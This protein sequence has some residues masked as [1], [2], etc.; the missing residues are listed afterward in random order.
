MHN[1]VFFANAL[2]RTTVVCC[3]QQANMKLVKVPLERKH[4][5]AV[6]FGT[7]AAHHPLASGRA[8]TIYKF[9]GEEQKLFLATIMTLL[10]CSQP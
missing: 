5:F 9:L 8:A 2:K 1:V 10:M 4:A 7:E 6:F 3:I